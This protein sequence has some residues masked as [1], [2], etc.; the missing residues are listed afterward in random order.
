MAAEEEG[1]G[2]PRPGRHLP[3]GGHH[4][5][6]NRAQLRRSSARGPPWWLPSAP[7]MGLVVRAPASPSASCRGKRT[8][9]GEMARTGA[10]GTVGRERPRTADEGRKSG[11]VAGVGVGAG[12]AHLR[13]GNRRKGCVR[14]VPGAKGLEFPAVAPEVAVGCGVPW[15]Q[16]WGEGQGGGGGHLPPETPQPSA[17]LHRPT[18]QHRDPPGLG[19]PPEPPSLR[20]TRSRQRRWERMEALLAGQPDAER[21]GPPPPGPAARQPLPHSN[22]TW[23]L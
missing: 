20:A 14:Q 9:K 7:S 21:V 15:E 23:F 2:R 16:C 5:A 6:G 10:S 13:D 22:H 17:L 3:P 12:A 8:H 4:A 1:G 11:E 19:L 18:G